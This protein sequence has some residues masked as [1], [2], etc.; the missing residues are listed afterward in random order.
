MKYVKSLPKTNP[1]VR[2]MLLGNGWTPIKEAPNLLMASLFSVPFMLLNSFLAYLALRV[3]NPAYANEVFEVLNASSW[4]FTIRFDYVLYVYLF[5]LFHEVLHLVLIP[6][7][8]RSEKTFWGIKPW[9]GFVFTREPL[10]R[11]RFLLITVAPFIVLSILLPA[12]LGMVGLLNGFLLFLVFLN[13]L[14][15]SVDMLNFLTI[16]LQVPRRSQIIN[17]GFESYYKRHSNLQ[18]EF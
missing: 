5:I 8:A 12:I 7:F 1:E 17:N 11:N 4:A 13:A 16:S 14:S 18:D 3:V 15:S 6:G 9:G 10:S 2:S